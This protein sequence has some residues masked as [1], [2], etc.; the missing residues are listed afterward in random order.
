M[1]IVYRVNNGGVIRNYKIIGS[2]SKLDGNSNIYTQGFFN[3]G[4]LNGNGCCVAKFS[5]NPVNIRKG[6]Y[7]NGIVDG[8]VLEYVFPLSLWNEFV[9][10]PPNGISVTRYTQVFNNGTWVS[11]TST[12][13]VLI[14]GTTTVNSKNYVNS[15]SFVEL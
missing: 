13:T 8:V 11:C 3:E 12:D 5:T 1:G 9:S 4:L 6:S 2:G 10:T 7:I 14:Q 15:F